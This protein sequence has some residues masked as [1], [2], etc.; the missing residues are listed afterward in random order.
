LESFAIRYQS[1]RP[2]TDE[3]LTL[4]E[5]ASLLKV[6]T[7]TVYAMAQAGEMPAFKVRGQ[8]RFRRADL[9]AWIA[10]QTAA[11]RPPRPGE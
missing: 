6:A 8:W 3:I 5:V 1:P 4:Q 2:L 11:R 9:D 10:Q 7:K